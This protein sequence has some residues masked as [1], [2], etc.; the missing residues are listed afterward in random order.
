MDSRPFPARWSRAIVFAWA[1]LL[2]QG[3][4]ETKPEPSTRVLLLD[5]VVARSGTVSNSGFVGRG[6]DLAIGDSDTNESARGFYSFNLENFTAFDIINARLVT[7]QFMVTGTPYND[8]GSRLLVEVVT[9]GGPLAATHFLLVGTPIGQVG[10]PGVTEID[11]D[12]TAAFRDAME[13]PAAGRHFE[14]RFRYMFDTDGDSMND[15]VNLADPL[16]QI[17]APSAPQL[18]ILYRT[19]F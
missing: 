4:G 19:D 14:I 5:P 11:F 13:R 18:E 15:F 2:L 10:G 16:N 1:A 9:L 17:G 3:C 6:T 7:T 12:V 8:L